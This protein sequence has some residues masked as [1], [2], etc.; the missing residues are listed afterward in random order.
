MNKKS[1]RNNISLYDELGN[2]WW[3][4]E[5]TAFRSLRQVNQF[6]LQLLSEWCEPL[7]GKKVLDLGCGGGLLSVPIAKSG[8]EV[9]ALDGSLK[10]LTTARNHDKKNSFFIQG[11][12]NQLPFKGAFADIILLADVLEHIPSYEK[13]LFHASQLLKQNGLL[14]VNTINRNTIA[15][16]LAVTL[17]EGIGFIPKGTHDPSLFI[18][19]DE[20]Q[21]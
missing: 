6:R 3:H 7:S 11:D 12:L 16:F 4:N 9:I 13:V 8:A 19:P 18:K 17:S 2:E 14:Y 20:L 5:S 1:T 15:S 10:S 21:S